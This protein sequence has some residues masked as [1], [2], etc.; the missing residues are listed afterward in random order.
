[1]K[2]MHVFLTVA[3]LAA[4]ACGKKAN[5]QSTKVGE[6]VADS[7]GMPAHQ[8][9]QMDGTMK[10][11]MPMMQ[12]Q[13]D[14]MMRM[15]PGQMSQTMATHERMMTEMMDRMGS[16]MRGMKMTGGPGWNALSDSVKQ[17]LAELPGLTGQALT[18]RMREHAGRVRR[19]MVMHERM[20]K[21][22]H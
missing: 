10:T 19:L 18:A 14:S 1:M 13:V 2:P 12:A 7:M 5:D 9:M 21:G 4:V 20:L 16:E 11:M 17:D 8:G 15:S 22:M 3:A 6:K